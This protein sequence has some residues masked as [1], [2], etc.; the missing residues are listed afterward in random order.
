MNLQDAWKEL[1]LEKPLE[2]KWMDKV[3]RR[4]SSHHPVQRLKRAY[5]VSVVFS[6]VFLFVFVGLLFQFKELV[7]Q[8]GIGV[9]IIA[10]LIFSWI[11]LRAYQKIRTDFPMDENL[12]TVLQ[13]TYDF[14]IGNI[15]YQE[16]VGLFIY[17]L[18]L[19]S[20]YLM[21]LSS[22]SGNASGLISNQ[23][24]LILLAV[25]IVI[26]TPLCWLLTRW[27]YR[28]AYGLFLKDLARLIEDLNTSGSTSI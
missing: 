24:I 5:L 27:M 19:T 22:S 16:R 13:N 3:H 18:A 1:D 14:V 21:G 9:M 15:R 25:A 8:A 17:P 4:I 11:N 2:G 20:G 28:V 6:V 23:V 26:L 7:V 12:K 10:Y